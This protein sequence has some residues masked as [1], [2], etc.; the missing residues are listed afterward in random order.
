VT[1]IPA[2][3]SLGIPG[4][5]PESHIGIKRNQ[6]KKN[7]PCLQ[8]NGGENQQNESQEAENLPGHYLE[9]QAESFFLVDPR[10]YSE[11][12]DEPSQPP[13]AGKGK[14]GENP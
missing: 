6:K 12:G 8:K 3:F 7:Q 1:Y 11:N 14:P 2:F 9:T 13:P 5:F 4:F 10:I